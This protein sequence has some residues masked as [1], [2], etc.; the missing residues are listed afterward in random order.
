MSPQANAAAQ[1]RFDTWA[2]NHQYLGWG[3]DAPWL[4]NSS[5]VQQGMA[6][7]QQGMAPVQQGMAPVQQNVTRTWAPRLQNVTVEASWA[8]FAG[9][10]LKSCK[11]AF[12][13]CSI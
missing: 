10:A 1:K 9:C 2:D 12:L 8:H 13:E 3:L 4:T 11:T 6:P 5:P 7:V